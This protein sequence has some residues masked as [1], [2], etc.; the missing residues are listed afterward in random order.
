MKSSALLKL[1]LAVVFSFIFF[2]ATAALSQQTESYTGLAKNKK[3]ELQYSEHH[4]VKFD[5]NGRATTAETEYKSPDGKVIGKM[6]SDFTSSLTAPNYNFIDL[7]TEDIH[8]IRRADNNIILF[9]QSKGKKEE[10]K[11]IKPNYPADT[12]VIGCQGLHYYLRE[13]FQAVIERKNIPIKFLIP[14]DLDYYNFSMKVQKQTD[15]KVSWII[16]IS[17]LFL[18]L[19]A[20]TLTIEY[21]KVSKK[22]LS[23]VGLSN[24]KN[25]KGELQ[26]VEITY[27]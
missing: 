17:N 11:A 23:Y 13:N 6:Q 9:R 26:I 2:Q 3:G 27:N 21:D 7:R 10:T 20:P 16:T 25:D 12:L 24:L 15:V 14:G 4:V 8:G 1:Y 19:F 18:K 5:E 22:L